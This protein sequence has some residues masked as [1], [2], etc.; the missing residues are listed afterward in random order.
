MEQ[1]IINHGFVKLPRSILEWEWYE[2]GTVARVYI[3]ILLKVNFTQKNWKG[4][5]IEIGEFIT[6]LDKLHHELNLSMQSIRTALSKLEG[7]GYIK[8]TATNRYTKIKAL[9]SD[10]YNTNQIVTNTPSNKPINQQI[11]S[12]QQSNNNPS[13]TTNKEKKEKTLEERKKVFKNVIFKEND[14]YPESLL[15]SF[16]N[17]WSE[18]NEQTGR[19]KFED[20]KYWNLSTRLSNWKEFKTETKKQP[21]IKNR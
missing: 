7:T 5:K 15:N 6:S 17:Y 16:F 12:E 2:D 18:E 8:L 3:H 11:T 9:N 1:S 19:L 10:V 20:E 14:K 4:N 21:F 13:T